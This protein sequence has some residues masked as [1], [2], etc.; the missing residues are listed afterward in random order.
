MRDEEAD[1]GP[2]PRPGNAGGGVSRRLAEGV[3]VVGYGNTLRSDDGVGVCAAEAVAGDARLG[4]ATVRAVH[5]LAPELA[6]EMSQASLVVLIDASTELPPGHV[7]VHRLGGGLASDA[8]SG[9]PAAVGPSTHHVG[10]AELIQLAAEL[11]GGEPE[12]FVVSVGVATLEVGEVL[13]PEVAAALPTVVDAV[14]RLAAAQGRT[15]G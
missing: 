8:G 1:D 15:A 2:G 4:G 12:V 13:S 6:P 9:T 14:A 11:Y 5:Q 7:A 10:P 3:L